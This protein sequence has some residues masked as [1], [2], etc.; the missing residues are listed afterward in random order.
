MK[1]LVLLF[2][3]QSTEHEVSCRSVLTVARAVN[4]D[5]Y[6]T[7]LIGITKT[8]EWIPVEDTEKIAD[9][10]WREGK[11]RAMLLPDACL[12][13]FV[14]FSEDGSS[15]LEK[16]DIVFPV[17]HGKGGED[18][19]VQGLLELAEIPYVGCGVLSSAISMDK[20]STKLAVEKTLEK[21]GVRQAGYI[22]LRHSE[23]KKEKRREE[24]CKEAAEELHF[25]MFVKPSNAGSSCGVS[26]VDNPEDLRRAVDKALEVDRRVLIEEYIK[27][28]EVECAVFSGVPGEVIASSVGEIKA[29]AEFYDYDAKYNNPDSKTELNP[30]LP[31]AVEEKI[32]KAAKSVFLAVDGFSLSRVDFFFTGEEVVFNEINTMPGFTSISMY[33]MLFHKA[34]WGIEEL[35]EKLIESAFHR[36]A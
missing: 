36:P 35:V 3:G 26:K 11:K 9:G 21:Q 12:K 5:K 33:P 34:G 25:P 19:T 23:W 31:S 16:A 30:G 1:N 20:V 6:R 29:A 8:G 15:Y 13:S 18:G 32:Q 7:Y 14:V 2:G 27:G 17:L 28:R 24:I 10:S 4:K 22:A